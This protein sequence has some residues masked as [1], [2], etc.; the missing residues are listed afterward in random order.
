[1][2]WRNY[3]VITPGIR[4]GKPRLKGT[5]LTVQDVMEYLAGGDTPDEL[6]A[7]FPEL[8]IERLRACFAFSAERERLTSANG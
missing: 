6:Q 5:R 4:S 2:D 1:M 8:T 7:A 3:I